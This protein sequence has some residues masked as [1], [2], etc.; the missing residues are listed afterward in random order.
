LRIRTA[1]LRKDNY[2]KTLPVGKLVKILALIR[3]TMQNKGCSI[4]LSHYFYEKFMV[5]IYLMGTGVGGLTQE[6]YKNQCLK[7]NYNE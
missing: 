2:F 5:M 4:S 7:L 3:I 1:L 6:I